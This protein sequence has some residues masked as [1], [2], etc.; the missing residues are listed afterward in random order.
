MAKYRRLK[1]SLDVRR[2][3]AHILNSLEANELE[4]QK[5]TKMAYI[6]NI[7]LKAIEIA[8][9]EQRLRALELKI[10]AEQGGSNEKS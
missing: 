7:L 9:V 8:E 1:T 4:P 10:Y 5:A 6:A 2:F 3:L